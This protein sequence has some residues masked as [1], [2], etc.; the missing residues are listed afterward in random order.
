MYYVILG[1]HYTLCNQ[2]QHG[3]WN[4]VNV[5]NVKSEIWYVILLIVW[6]LKR[7]NGNINTL[8]YIINT[9]KYIQM[10]SNIFKYIEMYYTYIQVH[11]NA[12]KYIQIYYKTP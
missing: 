5:Q 9:Y 11:L 1:L 10:H 3:M 12:F 2:W 4:I 8:K 6:K 7:T